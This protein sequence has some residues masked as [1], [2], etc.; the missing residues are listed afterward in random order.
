MRDLLVAL[1]VLS[2]ALTL[3]GCQSTSPPPSYDVLAAQI[4]AG[5]LP[6][7]DELRRAFLAAPELPDRMAHLTELELQAM[8]LV[9]DQPLKLGAIGT[10]ILDTYYGSLTGHYALERFYSHLDS[11]D[12]AAPH[13]RWLE[14]TKTAM[15][16]GRDGSRDA[17][18]FAMTPIEAQMYA[19]SEDLLPVG[20][21][22]QTNEVTAFAML[23]QAR[24]PKG[25]LESIHFDLDSIY[26]SVREEI[27]QN[28]HDA[29]VRPWELMGYLARDGDT[30]AQTAVGAYLFARKRYDDSATWLR[31]ASRTGNVLANILLARVYWEKST[32]A[33]TPEAKRDALDLVLENYLHAIALGSSDAMFALGALYLNSSFGE[34]NEGSALPLM[35]QAGDLDHSDALLFLAHLHY[36]GDAVER[37]L[38]QAEQY[39]I[40][41]AALDNSAARL[42]YARY[43]MAQ[44]DVRSGDERAIPWLEELAAEEDAE[45]ML[46]LGNLHAR[47]ITSEQN[48]RAAYRW[49]RDAAKTAAMNPDIVNEVAWTLTV[50]DLDD[51]RKARFALRIM[52]SLMNANDEARTR[53]EYLDTWAATHAA[54][55]DFGEA[56]RLQK[57]ALVEAKNAERDD[58]LDILQEHLDL[59]IAGKQVIETAP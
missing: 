12:A 4:A 29:E 37:D 21:M 31:A 46:L 42:S 24:R 49:Y 52:S 20:S 23:V 9:A 39:F 25:G 53:P 40:R 18:Y 35:R 36:A 50:S 2:S 41:S 30:A 13:K 32:E 45:A 27:R 57:L 7:V 34:E 58:V 33:T 59:F 22:Y 28:A 11:A 6:A 10:A 54:N 48:L 17:P 56:I 19:Q 51:L 5:E 8:Q 55:G 47:G 43:L 1:A 3:Q 44:R 16:E 14:A 38:G 26:Q 15:T